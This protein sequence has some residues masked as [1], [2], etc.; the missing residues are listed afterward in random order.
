M[1][2]V[3]DHECI[4][5]ACDDHLAVVL[6]TSPDTSTHELKVRGSLLIIDWRETRT[7]FHDKVYPITPFMV[8]VPVETF[9]SDWDRK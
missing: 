8:R 5:M 7:D 9:E 1:W 3:S 4:I 2:R 6:L